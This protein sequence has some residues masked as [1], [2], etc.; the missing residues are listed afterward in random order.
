MYG[1]GGVKDVGVYLI[2][3]DN[4]ATMKHYK[5]DLRSYISASLLVYLDFRFAH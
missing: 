3:L 1:V 4:E 5:S 2:S